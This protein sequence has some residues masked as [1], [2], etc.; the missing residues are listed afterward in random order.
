MAQTV[1]L[2]RPA[3]L[4]SLPELIG[5]ILDEARA[6]GFPPE[7]LSGLELAAEEALVNVASYAYPVG[8]GMV[9]VEC[10]SEG[11]MFRLDIRDQ[12]QPFDPTRAHAPDLSQDVEERGVGGLG[13]FFI[14][15]FMDQVSYRREDQSNI[16]SLEARLASP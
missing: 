16:L 6:G 4:D 12:G 14:K 5:F 11:G 7:R 9:S 2:S 10:R 1:R 13:V 8:P 3:T 15:R